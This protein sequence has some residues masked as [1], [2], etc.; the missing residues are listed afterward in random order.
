MK[1][2]TQN[3]DLILKDI[4]CF[5][6]TQTFDCGQCFRWNLS[7]ENE[8]TGVALG[9]VLRIIRENDGFRLL[10]TSE[11]DFLNVWKNY[12]DFDRDYLKIQKVLS[13]DNV[14]KNAISSGSG[15]R[16][17]RQDVFE[18]I[19]SF[20]ISANNNIP[21]IKLIIERFCNLFGKKISSDFGE[22]YSFP[23]IDD[24]KGISQADLAP[25]KAGFRDKYIID[26]INK[27]SSGEINLQNLLT[28]DY[29]NAKNELL[30]IK[31]VGEKVANCI[32]LFSLGKYNAFPVDVWVKRVVGHYYFNDASPDTDIAEFADNKFGEYGGFAQQYLFYHARMTKLK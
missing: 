7:A 22:F 18:T 25:I 4:N 12:F 24:L 3:N 20:I 5:D 10:N 27:I 28:L 1:I 9:H 23:S 6:L 29:K 17:L 14:L 16:I 2:L 26:A 31:G 21:R 32:L 11:D 13:S 8:Y 15:I 30:K 19:I